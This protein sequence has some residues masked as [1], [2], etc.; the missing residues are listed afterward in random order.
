MSWKQAK[1]NVWV[2]WLRGTFSF[3][4]DDTCL[5]CYTY[6]YYVVYTTEECVEVP[7]YRGPCDAALRWFKW[8]S[9]F[10]YLCYL[11]KVT[12]ML[13]FLFSSCNKIVSVG[14]CTKAVQKQLLYLLLFIFQRLRC[15]IVRKIFPNDFNVNYCFEYGK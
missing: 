7:R 2:R 9:I 4:F 3:S 8:T 14:K 10:D 13:K 11:W 15:T 6:C 5:A 1:N 12:F